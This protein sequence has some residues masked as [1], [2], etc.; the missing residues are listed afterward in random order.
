[1]GGRFDVDTPLTGKQNT[2][3]ISSTEAIQEIAHIDC[4]TV[5]DEEAC[6]VMVRTQAG[7]D[8]AVNVERQ[9]QSPELKQQSKQIHL[10]RFRS[11]KGETFRKMLLRDAESKPRVVCWALQLTRHI[12]KARLLS[13][14]D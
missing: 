7:E 11:G 13:E 8:F 10:I 5:R 4:A 6:A 2:Q 9:L 14:V 12:A 1:M 3:C